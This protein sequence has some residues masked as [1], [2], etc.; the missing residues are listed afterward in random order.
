MKGSSE[1]QHLLAVIPVAAARGRPLKVVAG[2]I[3]V[4]L[5]NKTL[6]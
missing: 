3:T 4:I 5:K 6:K 2:T 1:R